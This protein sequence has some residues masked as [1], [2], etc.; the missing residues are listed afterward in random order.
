M[1]GIK[2]TIKLSALK[3]WG[4]PYVEDHVRDVG[5]RYY[6]EGTR[7]VGC[8]C[9]IIGDRELPVDPNPN[10]LGSRIASLHVT[11]PACTTGLRGLP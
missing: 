6:T 5:D 11:V 2:L 7:D 8:N 9:D 3:S 4:L 1:D 10:P